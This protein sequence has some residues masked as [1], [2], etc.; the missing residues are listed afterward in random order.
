MYESLIGDIK[1]IVQN[2][3]AIKEVYAYPLPGNPT[4]YPAVIFFPDSLTNEFNTTRDNFKMYRFKMWVVVD[5]AGTDEE[6]V[7]TSILP[8]TVDKVIEAF[9]SA[10]NGGQNE[11][12]SRVWQIIDSGLWGMSEEQS[13]KRAWAELTLTVKFSTSA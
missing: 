9:D 5:L 6:T 8:K 2:I 7:F 4:K 11:D 10:W 3:S 1:T 12:G 13:G